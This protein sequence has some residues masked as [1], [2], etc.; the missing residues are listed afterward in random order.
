MM[1]WCEDDALCV[2]L[3]RDAETFCQCSQCASRQDG[4]GWCDFEVSLQHTDWNHVI[5]RGKQSAAAGQLC[6]EDDIQIHVVENIRQLPAA[7]KQLRESMRVSDS[8]S[9]PETYRAPCSSVFG[10]SWQL[11]LLAFHLKGISYQ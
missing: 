5:G 3:L 6:M 7:L 8:L 1:Q 9:L 10:S 11:D 4:D 2:K